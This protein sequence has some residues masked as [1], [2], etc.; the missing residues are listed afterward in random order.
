[1]A[2]VPDTVAMPG[3]LTLAATT[4]DD[5]VPK[6]GERR[7]GG[8]GRGDSTFM[9][10]PLPTEDRWPPGLNAIWM[11]YRGPGPVAFSPRG[12]R[13]VVA[14]QRQCNDC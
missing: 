3:N 12:Y 11:V 10:A 4:T 1:M 5:G 6:P 2:P 7:A 14:G 8:R 9:N 13:A